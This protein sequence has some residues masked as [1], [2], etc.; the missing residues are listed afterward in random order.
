MGVISFYQE[1]VKPVKVK[2]RELKSF[3]GSIFDTEGLR[4]DVISIVFC[5]DPFL[6]EMNRKFLKHNYL[7]DIITFDYSEKGI[8]SGEM[9]ISIER[10]RDNAVKYKVDFSVELLRVMIH[11]CLHLLG[12]KDNKAGEKVLM[13]EKE[14]FYLKK[15]LSN[16]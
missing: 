13:R 6:L 1:D 14:D 10:V 4:Y 12:Y 2:K 5:S 3:F 15:F 9:F 11:G 8:V 16:V 7:T